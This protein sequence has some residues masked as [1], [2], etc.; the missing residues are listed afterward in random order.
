MNDATAPWR[1]R[2]MRGATTVR[3]NTREAIVEATRELLSAMVEGNAIVAEDVASAWFTTTRDLNA[4]FPAAAARDGLGWTDT[5]LM[6]GHEMDVPESLQ[7][8]IR[9]LLHVNT[10]RAQHEI[11]HFYLRGAVVL[12]PDRERRADPAPVQSSES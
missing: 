3:E 12:R 7:H 10:Q 4:E 2:G 8:C 1:I 5:A 9:I 6:C 11:E